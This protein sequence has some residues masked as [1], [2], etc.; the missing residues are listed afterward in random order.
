[1][2]RDISELRIEQLATS[3][4]EREA[5]LV[6]L[7]GEIGAARQRVT[8]SPRS[9]VARA[10][11]GAYVG[12]WVGAVAHVVT[13]RLDVVVLPVVL[14]ALLVTLWTLRPARREAV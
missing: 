12:L 2:Y 10:T 8:H 4:L 13:E 3:V 11:W 7:D 1:M 5:T 6:A 9:V 14:G